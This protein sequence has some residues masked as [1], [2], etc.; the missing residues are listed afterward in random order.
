MINVQNIS[1]TVVGARQAFIHS[2]TFMVHPLQH[3]PQLF[4]LIH[5]IPL[6]LISIFYIC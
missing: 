1:P 5:A 6:S 3:P 4:Y 2:I